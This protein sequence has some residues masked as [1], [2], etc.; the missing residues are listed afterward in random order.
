MATA[1]AALILTGC[2]QPSVEQMRAQQLRAEIYTYAIR[3]CA[4]DF[5]QL[6]RRDPGSSMFGWSIERIVA[7]IERDRT[8]QEL[9]WEGESTLLRAVYDKASFSDRLTTYQAHQ[10]L[11]RE[12]NRE[13]VPG[14]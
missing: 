10:I 11:C 7:R 13:V 1:V 4:I 5:A 3:P 8:L 9:R 12:A 14:A 6:T 2:Q